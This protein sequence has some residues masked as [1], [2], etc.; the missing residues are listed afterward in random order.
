M[1]KEFILEKLTKTERKALIMEICRICEKQYR[2]GYQHG[3]IHGEQ[4]LVTE[5]QVSDFR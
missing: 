5:T 3:F 1:N 4:K 2:K